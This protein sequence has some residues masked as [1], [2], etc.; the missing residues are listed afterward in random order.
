M[1]NL[2]GRWLLSWDDIDSMLEKIEYDLRNFEVDLVVGVARGGVVPALS[3]SH[4]LEVPMEVIKWQTRDGSV[5]EH[6]EVVKQA[7][8]D[9]KNVVFVDD[10]NDSGKT[11]NQLIHAYGYDLVENPNFMSAVLVEKVMSKERALVTGLR[12]DTHDWIIFPWESL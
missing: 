2:S 9:G 11:L 4:G 6:N 5:Q 1:R 10:I 12:V 7:I 8:L 3:L